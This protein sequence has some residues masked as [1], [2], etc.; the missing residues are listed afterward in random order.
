[1]TSNKLLLLQKI[2]QSYNLRV[3]YSGNVIYCGLITFGFGL[4]AGLC[5]GAHVAL[6][7]LAWVVHRVSGC[8]VDMGSAGLSNF[9]SYRNNGENNL[10]R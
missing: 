1:M 2:R 5:K 10:R 9:R 6:F 4:A 3:E 8:V 7:F